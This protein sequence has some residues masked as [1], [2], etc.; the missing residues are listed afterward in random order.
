MG[1]FIRSI[2]EIIEI[3][4]NKVDKTFPIPLSQKQDLHSYAIKL[5]EKAT[6]CYVEI[7]NAILS[8]AAGYTDN[9]KDNNAYI[10]IVA[11]LHE[12]QGKGYAKKVINEFIDVCR[13]K[14]IRAVHL[15]AVHDNVSA[16]EMYRRLGF[17]EWHLADE[18]RPDDMHF[19][20]YIK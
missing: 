14:E 6:L 15:Y 5:A 1:D 11:T 19:I 8:M 2:V 13:K 20:Y 16:I 18:P 3:F 4:L 17:V 10:A 12:E 7:D 9:L